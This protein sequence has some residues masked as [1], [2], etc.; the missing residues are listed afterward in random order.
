[1]SK[2]TYGIVLG[3]GSFVVFLALYLIDRS[4]RTLPVY[5]SVGLLCL[6]SGLSLSGILLIPWFW[7]PASLAEKIWRVSLIT[8]VIFLLVGRFG[9]W[10]GF[11]SGKAILPATSGPAVQ[12]APAGFISFF[13]QVINGSAPMMQENQTE[14]PL[15]NVHLSVIGSV[16]VSDSDWNSQGKVFWQKEIDVGTVNALLTKGL[17]ERFPVGGQKRIVFYIFMQTRL[18][19]YIERMYLTKTSELE[20][21]VRIEFGGAA[22]FYTRTMTL[23]IADVP[24]QKQRPNQ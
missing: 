19:S 14:T 2:E 7:S 6:L 10:L 5:V 16:P 13:G 24:R 22:P 1:M 18:R 17:S 11:L 9:I 20:Y 4:G 21:E 23:R 12:L 3:I 15:D 8:A